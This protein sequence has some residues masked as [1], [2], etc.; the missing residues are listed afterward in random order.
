[1]DNNLKDLKKELNFMHF[2]KFFLLEFTRQLIKHSAPSEIFKLETILEKEKKD[3]LEETKEKIK[4][5]IKYREREISTNAKEIKGGG[6]KKIRSI[7]H[8]P[9]GMFE[10]Q[11]ILHI[12]PF[13]KSF[14]NKRFINPFE[15][16]RLLIPESRFPVHLQ[17]I[18]PIPVNKEIELG[19]VNPLIRDPMVKV[20]ECYGPGENLVVQGGMGIKKTG[21][22]LDKEEIDTVI[23]RFSRETRIP[24]QEGIFKVVAGKLIFLA[25]ISEIVGSKFIIKKM[26]HEQMGYGV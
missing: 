17:Y 24:V 23:Q 22:I 1:M 26:L 10:T 9:I 21:I 18:K 3:K 12:N 25:I 13:S 16:T 2:K 8:A 4:E 7:M 20:I 14:E 15:K 11:K 5:I 6:T 19:K